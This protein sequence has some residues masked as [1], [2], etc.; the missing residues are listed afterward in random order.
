MKQLRGI[1]YDHPRG[2]EPLKASTVKFQK[3]HPDVSIHW[4]IRS[5][6]DFEDY[7]V[8]LL[9]K[10]YDLI[11][12]D[13]PCIGTCVKKELLVP[14]DEWLP[15]NFLEDQKKNSVGGSFSS[16][17]WE[18]H[19]WALAIDAAAQV[20]AYRAD[21][22][23]KYNV[24]VPKTW[25]ELFELIRIL[26]KRVGI[27]LNPTHA[28]CSFLTLCAQIGGIHFWDELRGINPEV[29]EKSLNT[30]KQLVP[31]L[32]PVSLTA[33]PIQMSDMMSHSDEIVYVPLMFGYSNYARLGFAPNVIHFI[34]IPTMNTEPEGSVIGG[35]GLALSSYSQHKQDALDYMLYVLDGECQRGLYFESGGQPGHR[36]AWVDPLI[37]KQT[38]GFFENTLRTLDLS[39]TRPRMD[40]YITF[41]E[42]A[43]GIIH[44]FL[45]NECTSSE[46]IDNLTRLYRKVRIVNVD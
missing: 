8:E 20:S 2:F 33:N 1:T 42:E 35:V 45:R 46:A 34:D 9:V 38:H 32:H 24:P 41:Q 29:A 6:K 22:L 4:D 17:H 31:F 21:L 13:H 3:E 16:Y 12:L 25:E 26:P 27:P 40:G 23:E 15:T 7:P 28:Y 14:L 11:I 18:G 36:S 5:L 30:L 39:Y 44:S 10:K 37:N 43:G 19:Q